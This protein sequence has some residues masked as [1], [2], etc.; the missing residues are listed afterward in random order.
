MRDTVLFY[1]SHSGFF[2]GAQQSLELLVRHLDRR[3]FRA[4]FAGPEPG[5]LTA[6]LFAAGVETFILAPDAR[7]RS[8]GGVI[9]RQRGLERARLVLPYLTYTRRLRKLIQRERV[10]IVHC[11]SIRSLLTIGPAARLS[12]V[13]LIWHH[14]LNFD[15]GWWNRLGL[16]LADRII[17]VADSLRQALAATPAQRHKFV[18]VHNGVDLAAFEAGSDRDGTRSELGIE[19][20]WVAVGTMGSLTPRKGH[21]D[22]LDAASRVIRAH[23]R[24]RFVIVGDAE[25][26]E[27]QPY[28]EGL[29]ARATAA[30]LDGHVVFTGWRSDVPRALRGLDVFVL[31]SHNEGLSRAVLE[32]MAASLPVVATRVGGTADLVMEGETGL[33]VPPQAPEALANAIGRLLED[34][35]LGHSMGRAGRRRVETGFSVEASVHGVEAVMEELLSGRGKPVRGSTGL[36][37]ASNAPVARA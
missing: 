14:R 9:A 18:T 28:A 4:V 10:A 13:P 22:L 20:G 32:A 1:E 25:G 12:G 26:P 31:P 35:A 16:M 34:R 36:G 15:L 5:P 11:N 21:E 27:G 19:P 24:T 37:G 23:P 29:R 2:Y 30:G 3:R 17:V 8:Y 7:L 33:L 6:R